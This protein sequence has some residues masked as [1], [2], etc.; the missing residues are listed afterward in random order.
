MRILPELL[1]PAGGLAHLYAAVNNGADAVYLGGSRF[2]A[3]AKAENFTLPKLRDAIGYAHERNVKIYVTFN[4]LLRD[5]EL[6]DAL[7]YAGALWD[8]GA[9]AVI[10][11]DLGLVRVLGRY[12]PDLPLHLSTQ[13]T[14]TG[15][16]AVDLMKERGIRR[17]VPARE[18]SLEEI[19]ELAAAC[20]GRARVGAGSTGACAGTGSAAGGNG[21]CGVVEKAGGESGVAG[22]R[23]IVAPSGGEDAAGTCELEVFVHGA[24]CM[25]YS[26]Q[27]QM[28]RMLG[29]SGSRSGNRGLCAQPCRLPY[30]DDRDRTGYFLSPKDLCLLDELPALWEAGVDSLKIEGRLKSPEYVAVV[31]GIYR[32]YLDRYAETGEVRVSEEDREALTQIYSR[33]GFTT[34]YLHGNPGD[35]ILSGAS[36]KNSGIF[37]GRARGVVTPR[38]AGKDRAAASGAARKDAALVDVDLLES[39]ANRSART[40]GPQKSS[41]NRSAGAAGP[42]SSAA[43]LP[44]KTSGSSANAINSQM[45]GAFPLEEGDGVEIRPSKSGSPTGTKAAGGVVT[46]LKK[47]PGG[48]LRIGDMKGRIEPGDG[49][50]RVTRRAQLEAA[51][52]TFD[53]EDPAELDRRMVR[54]ISVEMEFRAKAGAP[55]ILTIRETPSRRKTDFGVNCRQEVSS[56]TDGMGTASADGPAAHDALCPPVVTVCSE[57]ALERA[58]KR[59]A[60]PD[61]IRRQLMKLGG[62]PFESAAERIRVDLDG[63]CAVSAGQINGLRREGIRQ[64]LQMKRET[65]RK[66]ADME[67]LLEGQRELAE[68]HLQTPESLNMKLVPLME[69]MRSVPGASCG[70]FD[71]QA[72]SR[73]ESESVDPRVSI[74]GGAGDQTDSRSV[75][76]S[77]GPQ[78]SIP[79]I[80]AVSKGRLVTYIEENFDEIVGC[81]RRADTGILIRTNSWIRQFLDAGVT[82]YGGYGLNVCN[83]QA[84]LSLEEIGVRVAEL[85]LETIPEG[86]IPLMITEHPLKT[87]TLT[88]RKGKVHRVERLPAGDKTIIW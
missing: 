87:K 18:L 19:R 50:W 32:K 8:I 58:E 40:A 4:T 66:P 47:L 51:R 34:G 5:R 2:N 37:I 14:V 73:S 61:R 85:S 52:A 70:A 69:Y 59:P 81:L 30:T 57:E 24:L 26:G 7:D 33:G 35:K 80:D 55:A 86:G 71:H 31:T 77:A 10:V 83:E 20:H 11:Q 44:M 45:R 75:S 42:E 6:P 17:I 1:A 22:G 23:G 39:A 82:V 25:C 56:V 27:C 78:V 36:P 41:A 49:I 74:D 64:L 76:E 3:R 67:R 53:T 38:T 29:A 88:D 48:L 68:S 16:W 12:L 72:D 28:S 15:K 54:K 62:T 60:D 63:T 84:R 21:A 13:G 9:D 43:S 79:Y 46:F 65:G